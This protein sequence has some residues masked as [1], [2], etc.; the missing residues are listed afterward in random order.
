M[1]KRSFIKTLAAA[2]FGFA[3]LPPATTYERVWRAIRAPIV[4]FWYQTSLIAHYYTK[5]YVEAMNK[6]GLT[7]ATYMEI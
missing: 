6:L 1:N 7:N 5:E 2:A 3:I 4:P